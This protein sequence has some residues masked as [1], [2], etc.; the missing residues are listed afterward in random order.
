MVPKGPTFHEPATTI[1]CDRRKEMRT[2]MG[3]KREPAQAGASRR[4][5]DPLQDSQA[6]APPARR[7]GRVH[8][9][10]FPMVRA[11]SLERPDPDNFI[12]VPGGEEANVGSAQPAG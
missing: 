5:L 12:V 11:K 3:F 6:D 9:F 10:D 1:E 4:H 2:G 8:R 7:I